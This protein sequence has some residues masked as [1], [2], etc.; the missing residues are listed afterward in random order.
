MTDV[1]VHTS[2]DNAGKFCFEC[3]DCG[4]PIDFGYTD[5]R[6]TCIDY[7]NMPFGC[8]TEWVIG[9]PAV[10]AVEAPE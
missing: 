9:T 10:D 3:P 8:G 5:D 7:D 2:Y 6:V 1:N 4:A